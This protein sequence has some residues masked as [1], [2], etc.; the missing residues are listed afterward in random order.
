MKNKIPFNDILDHLAIFT[1]A[2]YEATVSNPIYE[3][4]EYIRKF[5]DKL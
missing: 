5:T 3:L 4:V 2:E 1:L